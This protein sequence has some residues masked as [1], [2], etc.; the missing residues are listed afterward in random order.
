MGALD[1]DSGVYNAAVAA[2]VWPFYT[3]VVQMQD[4]WLGHILDFAGNNAVVSLVSDHGMQGAGKYFYPNVVLE[5]AGLLTRTAD[6]KIDLT[7]T[8]ICAPPWGEYFLSLNSTDWKGGIVRPQDREAALEQATQAL[9]NAIDPETGMHIVTRVFR[10]E[11]LAGFGAGGPTA[12]DLLMDF[13]PGYM[14]NASLDSKSVV[15]K[16]ALSVGS[17]AH[18]FFPPRAK[19]QTVWF[20]TGPGIVAGR[21]VGPIRQIDIAPTLSRLFGIPAPAN[22][23]GHVIGEALD[24]R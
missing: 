13:A 3:E 14:P 22:A 19:M 7:Q 5:R 9:L 12:G 8:R 6:N 17:G 24:P 1:P 21:E 23:T 4:E 20:A 10:P 11:D 15:R 2:K 18:G 16:L